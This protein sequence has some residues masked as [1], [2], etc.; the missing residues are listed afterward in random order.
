MKFGWGAGG[1]LNI[2]LGK[3]FSLEPQL[4]NNHYVYNSE[5]IGTLLDNGSAD[6]LSVPILLKLD[7]G[8]NFAI[9]AGPQFDFLMGIKDKNNNEKSNFT[10]TSIC[11][12][13][14]LEMSPHA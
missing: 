5:S 7:I 12:K 1:W 8:K 11:G 2:P 10:G 6:H 4:I 9:T 3:S 13:A 14:G